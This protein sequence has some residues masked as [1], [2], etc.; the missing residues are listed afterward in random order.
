MNEDLKKLIESYPTKV[1]WNDVV[2]FDLFDERLSAVDYLVVNTI[3]VSDGFIEFIPDNSP[4][5]IK[6]ILCWIWV[7]RPD[8][9]TELIKLT[10]I[11]EDFK[12]LLSSHIKKDMSSFWNYISGTS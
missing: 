10:Q 11:D 2:D 6:E 12:I 7:I 9:N 5:M 1:N 3:G 4:P 8:L